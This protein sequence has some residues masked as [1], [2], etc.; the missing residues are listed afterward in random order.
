MPSHFGF[1]IEKLLYT[2]TMLILLLQN[3]DI[4]TSLYYSFLPRI[5]KA[6]ISLRLFLTFTLGHIKARYYFTH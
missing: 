5:H 1:N 4:S 6:T 3:I 2:D